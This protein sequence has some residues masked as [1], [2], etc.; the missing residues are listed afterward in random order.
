[1]TPRKRKSSKKQLD[2]EQ[3]RQA[4]SGRWLDIL[5]D[6]GNISRDV[7]DGRHHPCPHCGGK[8]RFRLID[9]DMG[10]VLCNGCFSEA[11]GDGFSAVQWGRGIE[12]P[13]ALTEVAKYL[14]VDPTAGEPAKPKA[15]PAEHLDWRPWNDLLIVGWIRTKPPITAEAV[16]A[17]GGR[18]ARYRDQYTVIAIPIWGQQ[19]DAV[20]PVGWAMMNITG[21]TL[22]RFAPDK[23][24]E[25]ISK[26]KL[27]F[28]S[29]PGIMGDLVRL[30]A[31]DTA[32]VWKLEGVTD[33][34]SMLSM[35]DL[36]AD[37][38]VVTNSNGCKQQPLKW[39]C[40]L[41]A[42]KR[43]VNV[44]HDA[45][46]PGQR[47]ATG[48]DKNGKHREGW[49]E[50]LARVAGEVRNVELPYPVAETSG[51]DVRDWLVEGGDYAG[52]RTLADQAK[53]VTATKIVANEAVD[54]PHRLARL[55]L[56]QYADR[57]GGRTLK[58]WA[59][60]WWQWKNNHYR[61]INP[62]EVRARL[63]RTVKDEFDRINLAEIEQYH[64]RKAAGDVEEGEMPSFVI[65]VTI[66][67]INNVMA[68]TKDLVLM[69]GDLEWNCWLPDKSHRAY[70]SM[71]NGILDVAAVLADS[72]E[73]SGADKWLLPQSSDWFSC[74]HFPYPYDP[75]A[76]CLT[77]LRV[78]TENVLGDQE[79]VGFLQEWAGYLLLP[80]TSQQKFLVMTGRGGNGK[81]VYH[82]GIRAIIGEK[83]VS[84]VPLESFEDRFAKSVTLGKLVNISGDAPE[85]DALAEG[86]IKG[87]VSGDPMMF[88]RKNLPPIQAKPTARLMIAC[89]Q[90]PRIRDRTEGI[91]RR[92]LLSEWNHTISP[93]NRISG[94]D[95]SDWWIKSGEV[96]GMFNW[97]LDGLKR[98]RK[99]G[100]F[101]PVSAMDKALTVHKLDC[102]PAK[103]FLLDYLQPSENDVLI[104]HVYLRYR[105]WCQAN[106]TKPLGKNRFSAEV[107]QA[108]GGIKRRRLYFG[109]TRPWF[110]G[111]LGYNPEMI[112]GEDTA[113]AYPYTQP[114]EF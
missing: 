113:G 46:V 91:W 59:G 44:L 35:P 11:N 105:D 4:A 53:V 43:P 56:D 8:D 93:E 111:N 51:K 36:P 69:S 9:E 47:G 96:P 39:L 25:W 54:D 103:Q 77:W 101:P 106:G 6:V 104:S 83:N 21:G 48:W 88:D 79:V 109:T 26:P 110:F 40:E 85:L 108:F 42:S 33:M 31:K 41:I 15:D 62:E 84:G 1:M 76:T 50:G 7:L 68:A 86:V 112:S 66:A 98:L 92:M 12:F 49:A 57:T 32:M 100:R 29:S 81:S 87:F 80:D 38:A 2:V 28:G 58:F 95:E 61:P 72:G 17:A 90:L 60:S 52:L 27:T 107:D 114:S 89:N 97:A 23:P 19:L 16:Q 30:R 18:I 63:S 5:A 14:G 10:A 13:D 70:V 34:L 55:N 74:S 75:A 82:A 102:N 37:W 71:A 64:V 65:K 20:D 45:D 78:L 3:V 73:L 99:R 24:V 94:M 22:P 67:L